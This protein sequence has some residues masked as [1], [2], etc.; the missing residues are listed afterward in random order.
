MRRGFELENELSN[1][2]LI[3]YIFETVLTP[4]TGEFFAWG[5]AT[6]PVI[7]STGLP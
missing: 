1:R 5:M 4:I 2:G 3:S 6:A 7:K